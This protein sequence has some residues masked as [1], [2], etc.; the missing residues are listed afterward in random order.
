[1]NQKVPSHTKRMSYM[2]S[3]AICGLS[4][5]FMV[6]T[7]DNQWIH[8]RCGLLLRNTI[9]NNNESYFSRNG[10]TSKEEAMK[11]TIVQFVLPM[12]ENMG[13]VSNEK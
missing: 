12:P 2:G 11:R 1:M 8:K 9:Y 4:G 13:L 3:C 10:I 6:M 5:G 7:V